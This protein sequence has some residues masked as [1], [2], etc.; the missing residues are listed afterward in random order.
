MIA[1]KAGENSCFFYE[2]EKRE[3]HRRY[4]GSHRKGTEKQKLIHIKE[5]KLK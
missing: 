1:E 4:C 2:R 3:K 5:K